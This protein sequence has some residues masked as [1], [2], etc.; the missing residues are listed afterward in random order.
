MNNNLLKVSFFLMLVLMLNQIVAFIKAPIVASLFGLSGAT[1]SYFI[2]INLPAIIGTFLGAGVVSAGFIPLFTGFLSKGDHGEAWEFASA[3]ILS[4]FL[5]SLVFILICQIFMSRIIGFLAPDIPP[6][7]ARLTITLSRIMLPMMMCT[8]LITVASCIHNCLG[9]FILPALLPSIGSLAVII[10]IFP[11][12]SYLGILGVIV[13]TIFGIIAQA[14]IMICSLFFHPRKFRLSFRLFHPALMNLFKIGLPVIGSGLLFNFNYLIV[15]YLTSKSPAGTLSA[16][17]FA[18]KIQMIPKAILI[19]AIATK[20]FPTLSHYA[21]RESMEEFKNALLEGTKLV[22]L[23][24]LPAIAFLMIF[25]QPIVEFIFKRHSFGMEDVASTSTALLYYAPGLL[26]FGIIEIL[27]RAFFSLKKTTIVFFVYVIFLAVLIPL[28]FMLFKYMGDLTLALASSIS[29]SFASVIFLVLLKR[30]VSGFSIRPIVLLFAKSVLGVLLMTAFL[31]GATY[32]L[33][34]II[35]HPSFV[36]LG[37]QL[38]I[39]FFIGIF[40]YFVTL[41]IMKVDEA[42]LV[43]N[44]SK[45]KLT[46]LL[47][48]LNFPRNNV[49]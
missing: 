26:G 46:K 15:I 43:Y 48:Q 17:S 35:A 12:S 1:D 45:L 3:A 39:L 38:I 20:I 8:T 25:R 24:M 32:Y 21:G 7:Q 49:L 23:S 28:N 29:V 5:I 44:F 18:N 42:Y 16:L 33:N 9:K 40:V 27:S 14:S 11:L 10:L 41:L 19:L 30:H 34:K 31:I 37:L 4:L 6:E 13:A 2:A 22:F 36:G 47:C